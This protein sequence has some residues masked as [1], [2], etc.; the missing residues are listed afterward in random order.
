MLGLMPFW[1]EG[2]GGLRYTSVGFP[3]RAPVARVVPGHPRPAAA[4]DGGARL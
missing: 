4:M 2:N 3:P 1:G